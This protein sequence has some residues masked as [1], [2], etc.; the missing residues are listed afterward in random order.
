YS[1]ALTPSE[2]VELFNLQAPPTQIIPEVETDPVPGAGASADDIAIWIHPSDPA[3]STILGTDKDNGIG[4]YD[5]SG[6]EIGFHFDGEMN[7]IDLRY[8]FPLG[9]ELV[10]LVTTSNRDLETLHFYKVNPVS[11][12]LEPIGVAP[13][14]VGITTAYGLCM[15]HSTRTGK[16][17]ALVTDQKGNLEQWELFD[18]GS[19]L[20]D[21]TSVRTMDTGTKAEGC[22]VDDELGHLYIG[23]EQVGIW[24][25]GA[26]PGDDDARTQVDS[27][28][29]TGGH[30]TPKIEGL[31]LYYG[32][33]GAGYL[34][35][36][37]KGSSEYMIYDRQNENAYRA[38]FEIV[39]G[40]G[41]DGV[42]ESQGIDVTNFPLGSAFPM[43]VFVAMDDRN[44][45]GHEN[46]KLV[47]WDDL[48]R[49]FELDS[50][51]T[52][53]PRQVGLVTD[54]TPPTA[55]SNLA[56]SVDGDSV[57]LS[58]IAGNDPDSGVLSHKV[59]RGT[60]SGIGKT[61]IATLPGSSLTY[62]DTPPVANDEYFYEATAVN[63]AGLEG[64]SSSEISALFDRVPSAP[65]GLIATAN[66]AQIN[67]DWN[68]NPELDLAGYNVYRSEFPGGPYQ[69][70]NQSGLV[71]DSAYVDD[72]AVLGMTY[73]NVVTAVDS[74][75]QE[76]DNS[77][78]A[79]APITDLAV[80]SLVPDPAS[81]P[82][83]DNIDVTVNVS[84]LGNQDV[85]ADV[86]VI[87]QNLTQ[88]GTIDASGSAT[89]FGGLTAGSS[90]S[91]VIPWNTSAANP[92]DHTLSAS[93][94]LPD[95]V[96]AND[97][98]TGLANLV[99][100]V[101]D[102]SIDSVIPSPASVPVGDQIDVTINMS[103]LGN[104]DVLGD[105]NVLL[106]NLT[107]PGT[108]GATGSTTIFGG[109]AAGAGTSVVVPWNTT[110]ANLGDHT[111]SASHNLLDD[112]ASNDFGTGL[113]TVELLI[114]D[115][116]ITS[117]IPDPA[118]ALGGEQVD[119][120]IG[121]ANL[122]NQDVSNDVVITLEDLTH[123][124]LLGSTTIV[125]GLDAG[126]STDVFILWD[127]TG[128]AFDDHTLRVS[129]NLL[130]DDASN[131]TDTTLV[132]VIDP[133]TLPATLTFQE[134][135]NGYAGTVDTFLREDVPASGHGSLDNFKWDEG[136]GINT[137]ALIR[138]DDIFGPGL[139]QIPEGA[140]INSATLRYRVY[141]PG[142]PANLNEALADWSEDVA[143]NDF[144]PAAGV[145]P[146]D[147]GALVGSAAGD[148]NGFQTVDV[149]ASLT[150][151]AGDPTSNRGWIFQPTGR[152]GIRVR[153]SEYDVVADRPHLTVDYV[154]IFVPTTDLA[155]TSVV[156]DPASVAVGDSTNVTVDVANLGNQDVAGDII[157]T[158]EDQTQPGIVGSATIVGGLTAGSTTSVV[159]PWN[160]TGATLGDHTL[161][162]SHDLPDDE[163]SNDSGTTLVAV[164]AAFTDLAVTS[165][166][167]AS[168]TVDLSSSVDVTVDVS[169]LGNQ[170]VLVD[171]IVTLEDLTQPEVIGS[172]TIVGGLTAGSATSVVIPWAT[173]GATLGDHTL[174]AGHDLADDNA[175]ND[176][177]TT[178]VTVIDP[179]AV[180]TT[181]TFWEGVDGYAGTVDTFLQE[182]QAFRD[183]GSLAEYDWDEGDGRDYIAL[184]RFEDIF[185][186]GPNQIPVGAPINS[187]TLTYSVFNA[188]N[189]ANVSEV[190]TDWSETVTFSGFGGDSGVQPEEVGAPV[191]IAAGDMGTR[192][193]DVTASLA[194]W[195]SDPSANLGWILQPTG[196]NGVRIRSSEYGTIANRPR[197]TVD[198]IGSF[199]SHTDL[200]IN[201]VAPNPSSVLAGNIVDVT[202]DVANLGNENVPS[203]VL[204]TLENLTQPGVIGSAT[205]VGG[206]TAGSSTSVVIP[207]DT[208]GA[209][210]SD[211][212]LSAS[213]DLVDD[214]SSNDSGS[215]LVTVGSALT[216]L[217]IIS[218]VPN[219]A[220][221]TAGDPVDVT[222][223]VANLGNQ[224]VSVD[225]IVTLEDLTQPGIIGS[226][227][228]VG[229]LTAGS[230]T[231]VVI[232]WD[233]TGASAE[234]HTLSASHDLAND[235][236]SND[237]GSALTTV[238]SVFT[239][240]AITSVVP[241]PAAATVGDPVDVTVDVTNLGNQDVSSDIIV[242]L[243]DQT[244]PGIIG[245][246]TIVGGLTAGSA[247]SVVIPW[248]T[249]GAS[250]EDH[251]L[252]ASHDQADDDGSNDSGNAV[253]TIVDTLA[254]PT[255]LTFQE[256]VNGYAGT[257]DT[258]IQENRANTDLGSL[259][260][261]DWDGGVGEDQIALIRFE[262]IFGAGPNQIP[263]GAHIN[264]ATLTYSVLNAG[265]PAD[266][267]EV[268]TDWS[269]AV[270]FN[271]FGADP[272]VQPEDIGAS[273]GSATGIL[274]FQS[275]DVTTSLAAWSDAP[276]INRG[277]IFQP[278]GTNGVRI[279]SS[280]YGVL[281]NRPLLTVDFFLP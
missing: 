23:E 90:T 126:S 278:T 117:V 22:V 205:I 133:L 138:F 280:E 89:I 250:I 75:A 52:W 9:G 5:L 185:G 136:T 99:A 193:I 206:L 208:T 77:N 100:T 27:V 69:L 276:T 162:A 176:S 171:V 24:R 35:A 246:A 264:S 270:T 122:G 17:Y 254:V 95:D 253:V 62:T 6:T 121:V 56:G 214:D 184:I 248:D 71:T 209:S 224:D 186:S 142:D 78:E 1:G 269:E 53:D 74:I 221:V 234:D 44:D 21:A 132:T 50:D 236:S 235:D 161:R 118:G 165:V 61:L 120:T 180:P 72:T 145:Q 32:S 204:V 84:N 252:S 153:S 271:G 86:T 31:T 19:G 20:V 88:P 143:F 198:F 15:Y 263:V 267:N 105:I 262:D 215:A 203:D 40:N 240:L 232:P 130:D 157:V 60:A 172:A 123:P 11:R 139:N 85:L 103:N 114:T 160:T 48:D 10:A 223:D 218:M 109:L 156:S 242:T 96:S 239:D 247:T 251:T 43:G 25:F 148:P 272:G 94:N 134:G 154:A 28:V 82:V 57:S 233:T 273:V 18:N 81:V 55:P 30:L 159:I 14:E 68:D 51:P 245:S 127:T 169:N 227:T 13:I 140:H 135:V 168:V 274:G 174:S 257:V 58:W 115:L 210:L 104:Q 155:V 46:F 181:L 47:D 187:A 3:L 76:S 91:V 8:N 277:W 177:G 150:A 202:V 189:P 197:L 144:G 258:Y 49:F 231:S 129:H 125:G 179:F 119:V 217:A 256:G 147:V 110:G 63:A 219:P 42:T 265:N 200:A 70:P 279:R 261:F 2:V 188:G 113:A 216:D 222:I 73:F 45:D 228:I 65:T 106:Q 29:A 97:S 79:S 230:S 12:I 212:T 211:H 167:P 195:S 108:I 164:G 34:L 101:T 268:V 116:A 36:S 182:D 255:T 37:S 213:H 175:S 137:Y 226:T 183:H 102:I 259:A 64:A 83:G 207:W 54:V 192:S 178:M 87:L 39:D 170:D 275:L 26:E 112:N 163:A 33:N 241:N 158:L 4:V 190:A 107:Q 201:S 151:W 196:T 249:T 281:A 244:Q 141:N 243:E 260:E 131:D 41:L 128:A 191:G 59:Y 194:A 80:T 66:G 111:L 199:T 166:V 124:G 93:H 38:T 152:D 7:N 266:V 173:A 149:T 98:S 237:S 16:H 146:E 220:A 225:I 238:G 92:G 229:G 67:L